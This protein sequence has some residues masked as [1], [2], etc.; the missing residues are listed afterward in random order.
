MTEYDY[1]KIF[2]RMPRRITIGDITVRDGF[3]HLEKFISTRAK[4]FYAQEMILAGCRNLEVTNL[5]NPYGMPQFRDAE[6][7]LAALRSDRFKKRC[8]KQGISYDDLCLCAVTIRESAVDRAIALR[9]KGLGPDRC[10]MMVSTEEEHHFANSGTTLPEYWKEAERCI[11]KCRDAGMKMCGTVSTIWGSPIAGATELKDAVDFTKRWLEIGASDI[12]HADHDGSAS[13][14]DVYRYFS[15]ILDELPDTSLHIAH[16]H[17]TKRVASASVL[18]AL[19]AGIT[20]FEGTLGGLGGQPTNFL[21]D[22]PVPGTGDYYYEDPRFVGLACLEDMLVQVDEMGI[23][24]GYDVE[25]VLWL[26][27]QMEKTVGYRLRSEA[28]I[29][30]RTLKAGHPKFARP[31][32]KKLKE[33]LGEHP[34]QR[35]PDIWSPEPALPEHYGP[36]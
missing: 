34:G 28:A 13:A 15:M 7:I 6:E 30:G 17:E 4:I 29:N 14:P 8:Q 9:E 5:G 18:A 3:Q 23:D 19:Q 31:G 1:W 26:G 12:E 10:L 32:L 24:H 16:F 22:S 36:K 35:W 27:R 25:R 11:K 2:P 33:K 20:H 21:D